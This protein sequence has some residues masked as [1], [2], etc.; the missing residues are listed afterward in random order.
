MS[1]PV[2]ISQIRDEEGKY[3]ILW[4]Y[5][6][7]YITNLYHQERSQMICW[8]LASLVFGTVH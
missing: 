1:D 8:D 6:Y 4:V 7:K 2:Q 3:V 5:I